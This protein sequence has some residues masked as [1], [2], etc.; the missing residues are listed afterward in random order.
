MGQDAIPELSRIWPQHFAILGCISMIV[1]ATQL[2]VDYQCMEIALG[3]TRQ[4]LDSIQAALDVA[5]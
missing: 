2:Q 3:T 4:C 1:S 5:T